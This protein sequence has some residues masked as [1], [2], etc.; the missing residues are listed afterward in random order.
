M[1]FV[2]KIKY[3]VS[4]THASELQ[5]EQNFAE[6]DLIWMDW[7]VFDGP[8]TFGSRSMIFH[9]SCMIHAADAP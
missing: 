3:N 9:Y 5:S 2:Y 1:F 4:S 8:F 6:D 7:K